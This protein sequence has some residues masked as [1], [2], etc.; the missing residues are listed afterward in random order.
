MRR[1]SCTATLNT[2]A[3][4]SPSRPGAATVHCEGETGDDRK[5]TIDGTVTQEIGGRCVRGDLTARAGGR[6]VFR[7]AV[8]GDCGPPRTT[9]APGD[10]GTPRPTV[11]VTVTVIET[12]TPGK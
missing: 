1:L 8:L 11:T 2:R 9:P 4:A 6:T 7:A 5:I 10:H 3:T 12:R